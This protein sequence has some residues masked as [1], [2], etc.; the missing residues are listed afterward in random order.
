MSGK[1]LW[2]HHKRNREPWKRFKWR[3]DKVKSWSTL[4]EVNQKDWREGRAR[5][6]DI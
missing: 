3:S 2:F 1:K 6:N 4:E 5:Y